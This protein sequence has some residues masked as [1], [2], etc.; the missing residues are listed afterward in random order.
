MFK[1]YFSPELLWQ[2]SILSVLNFTFTVV[3]LLNAH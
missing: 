2:K 1:T 3:S